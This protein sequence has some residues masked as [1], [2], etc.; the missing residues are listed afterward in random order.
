M[1]RLFLLAALLSF[2]AP[3]KAETTWRFDNGETLS[4]SCYFG[5]YGY[6]CRSWWNGTG[7]SALV[8]NV[9]GNIEFNANPAWGR[10]SA[11]LPRGCRSCAD[12]S[13]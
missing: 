4:T 1:K 10:P 13:K 2:A 11:D 8:V 7:N 6:S 3:A 12:V 5:D 9:P